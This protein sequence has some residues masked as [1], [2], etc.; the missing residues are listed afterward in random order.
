MRTSPLVIKSRD[1]LALIK[2]VLLTTPGETTSTRAVERIR[3][4]QMPQGEALGLQNIA[5]STYFFDL[6]DTF[7]IEKESPIPHTRNYECTIL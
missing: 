7:I 5:V 2:R 3:T 1:D 6:L 4:A